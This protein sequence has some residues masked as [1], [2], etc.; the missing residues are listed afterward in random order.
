MVQT[1]NHCDKT[2]SRSHSNYLAQISIEIT[3][4]SNRTSEVVM[5]MTALASIVLPL[6]I[7]TG[8]WGMNVPVP[9]QDTEGLGG[10]FTIVGSMVLVALVT[11]LVVKK[12][13]LV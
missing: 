6:N 3:Q 5:R 10:F 9:G 13:K 2:L 8:L 4:A 7:I 1:L 11:L 12:L